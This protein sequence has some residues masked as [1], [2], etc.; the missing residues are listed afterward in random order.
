MAQSTGQQNLQRKEISYYD[1]VNALVASNI[2]KKEELFHAE[3]VRSPM[4]GTVEKREGIE[5]IGQTVGNEEF[6]TTANHGLFYFSNEAIPASNKGLYR[7]STVTSS[8]LDNI[9]KL[10]ELNQWA[11]LTGLGANLALP[12][13]SPTFDTCVAEN[14]L[15]IANQSITTRYILGTDGVSMVDSTTTTGNLY[16]CPKAN[17]IN[18][19]KGRL[20]VADYL[21]GTV[22]LKNTIL[23]SSTQLGIISLVNN[24]VKSGVTEIPVTDN[25]YFIQGETVQVYR[26][27]NLITTWTVTT[28]NEGSIIVS[29]NGVDIKASDEIWVNGTYGSTLKVFRWV[30]NPSSMGVAAKD[31]DTFKLSSTT[32]NNDEEIT[33]MSNVGNVM[34][35]ASRSN[36]SIWNDYV[37]QNLDLGLGCVSRKAYVKNSGSMYFLH[38]TGIYQTSGGIPELKSSKVERYLTGA[39]LSGLENACAGKKGRSVF[40]CI[41]DVTLKKPDGSV[42]K[43]LQ[44][45]CLEYSITQENWYIHTGVKA[46]EMA[47]FIDSI[48]Y[49][50]CVMMTTHDNRPVCEFLKPGVYTDLG[51]EIP[52]RTDTP[53]ILLGATFEKVSYPLEIS[54]EMERGSGM[55][56]FASLDM[57]PWYE[58]EGEARKGMTIF[59]FTRKGEDTTQPPRC[60]NVRWSF[61]H[62]GKQSCV[63]AK[64]AVT[65]MI[66]N[67][68]ELIKP[69]AE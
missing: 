57:S 68:E 3:N 42:E 50:K 64:S 12:T 16:N 47:T 24:D 8:G 2:A 35:I 15:Y 14:N 27:K 55:K 63:I 18:Y 53:N 4:V 34:F 54:T 29:S 31:Y 51:K 21:N 41:G 1:G 39:T 49:D 56:C 22:R 26:G 20:Y 65:Y 13:T 9:Y 6:I 36:I 52:M 33:V 19:F 38:Y 11:T 44:D 7:I 60:R 32:D 48:D 17:L 46:S 43:I 37:L 25:K 28:I 40:F 10:N 61:R 67:E 69:D 23:R 5:L 66:S 59:K 30:Y 62:N 45:V 58:L